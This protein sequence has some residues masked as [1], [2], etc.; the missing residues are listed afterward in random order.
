MKDLILTAIFLI[1][2]LFV[3]LGMILPRNW[4]DFPDVSGGNVGE[5]EHW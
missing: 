5:E 3:A 4:L 2:V 1:G